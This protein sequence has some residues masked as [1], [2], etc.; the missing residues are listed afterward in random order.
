MSLNLQ[1]F[2]LTSSLSY[3]NSN[4]LTRSTIVIFTILPYETIVCRWKI[5]EQFINDGGIIFGNKFEQEKTPW[6]F[7]HLPQSDKHLRKKLEEFT[8]E[9]IQ[10]GIS[11][12]IIEVFVNMPLVDRDAFGASINYIETLHTKSKDIFTK[13]RRIVKKD[14]SDKREHTILKDDTPRINQYFFE[15]FE[16][17]CTICPVRYFFNASKI[18]ARPSKFIYIPRK[19]NSAIQRLLHLLKSVE[20]TALPQ[21]DQYAT[22]QECYKII[23]EWKAMMPWTSSDSRSAANF[24][25]KKDDFDQFCVSIEN[26]VSQRHMASKFYR[27]IRAEMFEVIENFRFILPEQRPANSEMILSQLK[28]TMSNVSDND[29][30]P[31]TKLNRET[32]HR[33]YSESADNE[34]YNRSELSVTDNKIKICYL[35]IKFGNYYIQ[36]QDYV[37][38]SNLKIIPNKSFVKK[39]MLKRQ[40][41]WCVPSSFSSRLLPSP[42]TNQ[43]HAMPPV[44]DQPSQILSSPCPG[45]SEYFDA[46]SA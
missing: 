21:S 8:E 6:R 43:A 2:F 44:T 20:R 22:T 36:K 45:V 12:K 23:K 46:Q 15:Q 7:G 32:L 13:Q 24:Y 38:T 25:G 10:L 1:V 31:K 41:A 5:K 11:P 35:Y 18:M 30:A 28:K 9:F 34:T 27:S 29:I 39:K 33:F 42:A 26:S 37:R 19:Q 17:I 14:R 4:L 3:L 40:L 16:D